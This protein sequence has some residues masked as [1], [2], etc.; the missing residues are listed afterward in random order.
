MS[1]VSRSDGTVCSAMRLDFFKTSSVT[2]AASLHGSSLS[3]FFS[4]SSQA[5]VTRAISFS[6]TGM[7]LVICR[8]FSGSPLSPVTIICFNST[9]S[10]LYKPGMDS[11]I[12]WSVGV[13]LPPR[14]AVT[15]EAILRVTP[16]VVAGMAIASEI[17]VACRRNLSKVTV[18]FCASAGCT[19]RLAAAESLT[20]VTRFSNTSGLTGWVNVTLNT[21]LRK[22]NCTGSW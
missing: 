20:S 2:S 3:A 4:G 5:A 7:P 8:M 9:M 22:V 15:P 19:N 18:T 13:A 11:A 1:V 21:A 14:C 10:R 6:W 12:T 17:T 16:V